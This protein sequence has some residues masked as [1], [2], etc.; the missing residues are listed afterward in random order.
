MTRLSN[1]GFPGNVRELEAMM[2]DAVAR[3]QGEPLAIE[4]LDGSQSYAAAGVDEPKEL[5]AG[6]SFLAAVFGGFPTMEKMEDYMIAEALK[7]SQGNQGMAAQ[8]LGISR[9]TLNRRLN[10]N[11]ES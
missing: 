9:Q 5:F 8:L 1:Y 11:R 10:S 4:N 7:H 3:N 2:H 6:E